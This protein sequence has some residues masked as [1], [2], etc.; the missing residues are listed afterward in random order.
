MRGKCLAAGMLASL[1]LLAR[2]GGARF[3]LAL[4]RRFRAAYAGVNH[5]PCQLKITQLLAAGPVLG[6]ALLAQPLFKNLHLHLR[7]LQLV[8]IRVELA[9]YH[10]KQRWLQLRFQLFKKVCGR[11]RCTDRSG[12]RARMESHTHDPSFVSSS[13]PLCKRNVLYS[14]GSL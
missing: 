14:C 2:E 9:A 1:L 5:H 6:D 7:M 3:A 8:L 4:R 10:S 13:A 12:L 11:E